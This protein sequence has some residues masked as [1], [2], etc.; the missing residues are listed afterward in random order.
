MLLLDSAVQGT[1]KVSSVVPV[2]ESSGPDFE[3]GAGLTPA[4][5]VQAWLLSAVPG[6]RGRGVFALPRAPTKIRPGAP[7]R[8][9]CSSAWPAGRLSVGAALVLCGRKGWHSQ[10]PSAKQDHASSV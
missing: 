1:T 8:S 4:V 3:S 5:R 2:V 7:Q 6:E 9:S 10:I